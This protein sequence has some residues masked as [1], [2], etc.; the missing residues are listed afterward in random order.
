MYTET[1]GRKG[2]LVMKKKKYSETAC[3]PEHRGIDV[4]LPLQVGAHLSFHLIDLSESE[5]ALACDAP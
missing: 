1:K 3:E 5:H 2:D 4:E